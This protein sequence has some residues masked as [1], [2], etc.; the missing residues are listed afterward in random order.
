[1]ITL[2]VSLSASMLFTCLGFA[3][4]PAGDPFSGIKTPMT[5][6]LG[7]GS[8]VQ[9]VMQ[10]VAALA[11]LVG[12]VLGK[13]WVSGVSMLVVAEIFIIAINLVVF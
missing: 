9:W 1:M 2:L 8:T 4:V 11:G 13:N 5:T 12:G 3:A 10:V 6:A 7:S